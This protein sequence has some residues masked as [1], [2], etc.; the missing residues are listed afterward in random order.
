MLTDFAAQIV[1][2]DKP[3]S[4][5]IDICAPGINVLSIT[6]RDT[7]SAVYLLSEHKVNLAPK[8]TLL[9]T[10]N[11]IIGKP[12]HSMGV[13]Q[14]IPFCQNSKAEAIDQYIFL[15]YSGYRTTLKILIM[16][17]LLMS[18]PV[19]KQLLALYLQRHLWIFGRESRID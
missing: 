11:S 3:D 8:T 2:P 15:I 10:V 9:S 6:G 18:R 16:P 5:P 4:S 12:I 17:D 7:P 1:V 13:E 19:Q 14:T